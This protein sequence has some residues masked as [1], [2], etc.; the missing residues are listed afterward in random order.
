MLCDLCKREIETTEN[1]NPETSTTDK[2]LLCETCAD[3][4]R[5]LVVISRRAA[6]AE[7]PLAR[8]EQA[9][10]EKRL[11]ARSVFRSY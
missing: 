7:V 5:R 11:L 10:D 6:S 4:I 2:N 8:S 3:A 1:T 9:E